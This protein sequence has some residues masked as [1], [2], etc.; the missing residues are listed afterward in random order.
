MESTVNKNKSLRRWINILSIVIPLAVA[1]LFGIK[2][3]GIDTTFLPPIYAGINGLT[4]VLLLIALILVKNRKLKAH[5][6]VIKVCMGLSIVFLLCYV[7]YHITTETTVYGGD[8]KMVYYPLLASHILLSVVVIPLVL[9]SYLFAYEGN[10]ERH[11]K[12]TKIAWPVWFYVAVTGVVVYFM[13]AP[14]Y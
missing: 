4:A 5:E 14:Y 10:Y 13:I 2:L 8:L 12:W 1:A 9:Y 7:T 6:N 3:K 11:R